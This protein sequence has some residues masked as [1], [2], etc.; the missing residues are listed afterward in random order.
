MMALIQCFL[1]VGLMKL[2]NDV[3][4]HD[5][6]TVPAVKTSQEIPI[7]KVAFFPLPS[8]ALKRT[9]CDILCRVRDNF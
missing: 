4:G 8:E 5:A 6:S 2:E 1:T 9:K 7:V 3:P